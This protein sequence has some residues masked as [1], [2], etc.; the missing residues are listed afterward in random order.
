MTVTAGH[1]YSWHT[2]VRVLTHG[3][4]FSLARLWPQPSLPSRFI[5]CR[6]G[7]LV[8]WC[9]LKPATR[10]V[11][12][13]ASWER[14]WCKPS[15]SAIYAQFGAVWWELQNDLCFGLTLVQGLEVL[16]RGYVKN[17]SWLLLVLCLAYFGGYHNMSWGQS[18]G[19]LGLWPLSW[20]YTPT[21]HW[22]QFMP[23]L[24]PPY[25]C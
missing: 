25:G 8:L 3:T 19:I 7:S 20:S 13:E 4:G 10:F 1:D 21:Q 14:L 11:G 5:I 2:V 15:S 12:P 17:Q 22:M 6:D 18:P 23:G 24:V 16:G 9:S